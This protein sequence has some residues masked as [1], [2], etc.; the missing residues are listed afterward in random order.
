VQLDG[1][2]AHGEPSSADAFRRRLR[3]AC[4][5]DARM[6]D[7]GETITLERGDEYAERRRV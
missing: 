2:S 6:P 1:L 7:I 5:W 4:Q 3:E